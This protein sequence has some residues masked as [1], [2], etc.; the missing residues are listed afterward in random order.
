MSAEDAARMSAKDATPLLAAKQ[1]VT[2]EAGDTFS[3]DSGD[4][5]VV[6]HAPAPHAHHAVPAL[7]GIGAAAAG[8]AALPRTLSGG[9]GSCSPRRVSLKHSARQIS[10]DLVRAGVT[11]RERFFRMDAEVCAAAGMAA[12]EGRGV[13]PLRTGALPFFR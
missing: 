7:V 11:L 5:A 2:H 1:P 13:P 10:R 9:P 12:E 4:P 8:A 6:I 3:R